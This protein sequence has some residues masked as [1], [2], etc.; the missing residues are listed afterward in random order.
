VQRPSSEERAYR[1]LREA[2][3][4][5]TYAAGE[6]LREEALALEFGV[7]RTPVRAALQRLTADGLIEYR[8]FG[9]AVVRVPQF[10]EAEQILELRAVVEGLAAELAAQR[11]AEAEI[12]ALEELAGAMTR[13]AAADIPD[14]TELSRLNKRFHQA[15]LDASGNLHV[16]RVAE[17]LSDLNFMLR[18]YRRYGRADL[19]RAMAQHREM[20]TAIRARNSNWARSIMVAHIEATRSVVAPRVAREP[21]GTGKAGGAAPSRRRVPA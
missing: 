3:L 1:Y 18:S 17:N 19:E 5:G 8:R 2:I 16:R 14:L 4:G 11:M 15:I 10:E 20:A 6:R 21:E 7:S 13:L 12:V 9:G